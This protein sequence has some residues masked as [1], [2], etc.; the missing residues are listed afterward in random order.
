MATSDDDLKTLVHEKDA[1]VENPNSNG[2]GSNGV[3]GDGVE[4][5]LAE[6]DELFQRGSKAIEEG[7]YNE[8]ADCLSRA[9]EIKV[10]H[11]GEL[12]KECGSAYYK[13]G[14]ALLFKAQEETD[15]LGNVPNKSANAEKGKSG[16]VIDR[17]NSSKSVESSSANDVSPGETKATEG[18][19]GSSTKGQ[20]EGNDDSEDEEDADGEVE[21]EEDESDLDLAWKMLDIARVIAEQCPEDTLEKVNIFSALAEVAMEREDLEMSLNDYQKALAI[22]DHIVEPDHR[23]VVELNFRICLVLETAT[24]L[25]EA[26]PYCAKA[27]S[28]SKSRIEKLKEKMAAPDCAI[29]EEGSAKSAVQDEIELLSG[30]LSDLETKLEDLEQAVSIP[31]S[32]VTEV[33]EVIKAAM[34]SDKESKLKLPEAVPRSESLSSSQM[35]TISNGFDSPTVSTAAGDSSGSTV[36]HLGVVGRGVKRAVVQPVSS[37]EHKDKKPLTESSSVNKD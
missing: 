7:D 26:L 17:S 1:H 11:H 22:L 16:I 27:I 4:G 5:T 24:R 34:S 37:A 6:A 9:L 2:D 18:G 3:E 29:P 36:T 30:I 31:I 21:G 13:Y 15:P 14:C 19:E 25:E 35:G 23:R 12:A 32:K 8:A 20:L 33:I 28:L 10:M